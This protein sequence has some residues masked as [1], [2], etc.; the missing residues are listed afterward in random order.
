MTT[1]AAAL[2]L[3]PGTAAGSATPVPASELRHATIQVGDDS[4][5]ALV[6]P[7]GVWA[8]DD[9]GS[10]TFVQ[11]IDPRVNR[12]LGPRIAL[13]VRS[14]S[15]VEIDRSG[16]WVYRFVDQSYTTLERVRLA[17]AS[18]VTIGPPEPVS[19]AEAA[20]HLGGGWQLQFPSG[21]FDYPVAVRRDASG[22]VHVQVEVFGSIT[23]RSVDH[24]GGLWL[25]GYQGASLVRASGER[26]R[27]KRDDARWPAIDVDRRAAWLVGHSGTRS[28]AVTTFTK[29]L[30]RLDLLS[31]RRVGAPLVLGQV[32]TQPPY[33]FEVFSN[34]VEVGRGS[35][36]VAGPKPGTITR[37]YLPMR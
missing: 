4:V 32:S 8:V 5:R 6:G 2:V 29:R 25:G 15:R 16:I 9:A 20:P 3:M 22:A 1:L 31:G 14:V 12:P 17:R 37:V 35:A 24:R 11:R 36:W 23:S 18:G 28:G 34:A 21:E 30:Y 27:I 19:V 33:E 26:V 10:P 7:G 13:H